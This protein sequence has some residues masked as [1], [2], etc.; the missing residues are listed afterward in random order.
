MAGR[1]GWVEL[2]A[3]LPP[4]RPQ[5]P[6][7]RHFWHTEHSEHASPAAVWSMW[8]DVERWPVFDTGLTAA[9]LK[10]NS[11]QIT[12]VGQ[13]GE[14]VAEGGRVV[15]FE[16]THLAPERR[17]YTFSSQL[18]FAK[19]HVHRFVVEQG[20]GCSITH[21]VWFSGA[22]APLFAALLGATFRRQLPAV[23]KRVVQLA[24]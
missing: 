20:E 1:G 3:M 13:R 2:C 5:S 8:T 14:L 24:S 9:K 19:L 12:A 15:N 6:T 7:R 16:I 23:V 21:E 17:Q 22:F 4:G 18:I 11:T 10:D